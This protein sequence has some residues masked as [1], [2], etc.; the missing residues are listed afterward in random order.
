M[1]NIT[2]L[3]FTLFLFCIIEMA[4]LFA[5]EHAAAKLRIPPNYLSGEETK[6][7]ELYRTVSPT[8]VTIIS[9]RKVFTAE[10]M[11]EQD[12][13]GSGVLISPEGHVLTAAHVL[14]DAEKITVKTND[15][16]LHT[17]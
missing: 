6:V 11:E 1:K 10:G 13:I 12:I 16:K 3:V 4:P 8:V 9:L 5:Q 2:R 15:G 14:K 17:A 7:V